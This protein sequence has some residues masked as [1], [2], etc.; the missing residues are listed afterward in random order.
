MVSP[1]IRTSPSFLFIL[2][3]ELYADNQASY[4][5]SHTFHLPGGL[6]R[7]HGPFSF[8]TVHQSLFQYSLAS[9]SFQAAYP[10]L[11]ALILS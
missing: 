7:P 5:L 4:D 8:N 2:H 3:F 10:R 6:H 11:F 1:E 9:H